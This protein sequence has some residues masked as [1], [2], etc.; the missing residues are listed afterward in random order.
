MLARCRIAFFLLILP[1]LTFSAG[2]RNRTDTVEA[3]LRSREKMYRDALAEN[4]LA[5]AH[6]YSLQQEVDALRKG[7]I[8]PSD[9][10]AMTFGLKRITL[11]RST[12]GRDNDRYPGDEVLEV[13]VEPRDES[14]HVTKAPGCLQIYALE[15]SP[16]GVKTPLCMWDIGAEELRKSW[17]EGLLSTG[18]TLTLPWKALPTTETVRVIVRLVTSDQRVY[19]ADKDI[20]VKLLPGAV[21]RR[22]DEGIPL[23]A[24]MPVPGP[25]PGL[26]LIQMGNAMPN[27]PARDAQTPHRTQWRPATPQ[28]PGI[29][30]GDPSPAGD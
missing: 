18:Y 11:G 7:A 21:Q 19:E 24:P 26:D 28:E 4:Q 6:I 25:A 5:N 27:R 9:Q 20:K 17:K 2:C 16:S 1:L 13:V 22:L 10:A 30:L 14:D 15:V 23:H 8:I 12:G 3:E 29:T